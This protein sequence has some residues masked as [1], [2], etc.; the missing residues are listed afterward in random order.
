MLDWDMLGLRGGSG[1]PAFQC[2]NQLPNFNL[3]AFFNFDFFN[4]AVNRRGNFNYCFIGFQLHYGLA[5]RNLSSRR[6]HQP[7][8]ISLMNVLP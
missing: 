3:F 4:Y 6:N 2:K 8:Q 1:G 5:F 7:H